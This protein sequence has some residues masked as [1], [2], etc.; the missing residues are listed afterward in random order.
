METLLVYGLNRER[1]L[2][3]PSSDVLSDPP[4]RFVDV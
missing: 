1:T 4:L 2:S 3:F